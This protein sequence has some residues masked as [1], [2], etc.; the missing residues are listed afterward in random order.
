MDKTRTRIL[1]QYGVSPDAKLSSGMEAEVYACG[2][3]SVLKLYAGTA[4]LADLLVLQRFYDTLD[5]EHLPYALPRIH[6]VAEHGSILVTLEQRLPGVRLSTLL[7]GLGPDQLDEVMQR[8]LSAAL[9]L[10]TLPIPPGLDRYKLFDPDHTSQ[11]SDGDWHQFLVRALQHKLA[12]VGSCLSRDVVA[13]ESKVERLRALLAAPYQ[14]ELRLI[15]GDFFPGNLLVDREG[16]VTALLD[17]GLF[18]MVGDPLFDLATGWVFFDMY[19]ELRA[20]VRERYLS[21][22][23]DRLGE[24]VRRTLY[25]YV[26]VYSILSANTYSPTC[27]DGHYRWC[28]DNLNTPT[29][30]QCQEGIGRGYA[31]TRSDRAPDRASPQPGSGTR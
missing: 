3:E 2:P 11:R 21:L 28:A 10:S 16:Q 6:S 12:Q 24:D 20:N 25:R 1:E 13:F 30:W 31:T 4:R 14:G 22:I 7:P 26:L 8:T 23:L 27:S 5:R 17:F 9:A 18:T 15:H 19:D 29:F